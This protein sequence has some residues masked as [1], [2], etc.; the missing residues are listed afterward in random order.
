MKIRWI[1]IIT[2]CGL[3]AACR[4]DAGRDASEQIGGNQVLI[5]KKDLDGEC[6]TMT[7]DAEGQASYGPCSAPHST[8]YILL[9]VERPHDLRHF[10]DRYQPF[11]ANTSAGRVTL[12]GRGTQVATQPEERALAEW[13]SLVY[14]ELQFG[15]SGASWG[16]AM[17]LNQ[18]GS[19]P[20]NRIQI[21]AYGKVFANDCRLGIQPYPT[22]WLTVEQVDCLYAWMDEFRAFDMS[23]DNDGLP[24]L[25]VFSGRGDQAP[26]EADQREILAWVD[27]LYQS[28]V[29]WG[30]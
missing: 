21:E 18:E 29:Q 30:E 22:A 7:I 10:S 19:N 26:S 16:L 5:W 24:M 17:A 20:C 11:E 12:A 13:A 3:L 23:W 6:H 27:A 25:L 28:I 1:V 14:R 15:R 9:E 2:V 4:T 8:A